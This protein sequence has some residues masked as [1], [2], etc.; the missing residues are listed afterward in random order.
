MLRAEYR[1]CPP[2][3]IRKLLHDPLVSE[4]AVGLDETA[5]SFHSIAKEDVSLSEGKVIY[6]IY[7]LARLPDSEEEVGLIINVEAQNRSNPG[8]PLTRRAM[9]Y[10][11]RML[12][13]QFGVLDEAADYGRLRKVYS[14]WI[15]THAKIREERNSIVEYRMTKHDIAGHVAEDERNYD[16]LRVIMLNL[17]DAEGTDGIL[18]LMD[19]LMS[20]K[21]PL[22]TKENILTEYGIPM[23]VEVKGGLEN[24]CN[25]SDG[26]YYEGYDKGYDQGAEQNQ[27]LSIRNLMAN[28]GCSL[29]K[30]MDLLGIPPSEREK[31]ILLLG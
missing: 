24:M 8:Y 10:G 1:I 15:C 6:D 28:L 13:S 18:R 4:V 2:E 29:E 12:S 23:T 17:G 31:L 22:E 25:L 27:L 3:E 11:G 7:F 9:Y 20:Q 16:L 30:A 19:T 5:P 26:I 14:I 21:I